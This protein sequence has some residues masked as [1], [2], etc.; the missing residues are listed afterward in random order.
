MKILNC[1]VQ[2]LKLTFLAAAF[3]AVLAAPARAQIAPD[4]EIFIQQP[5]GVYYILAANGTQSDGGFY[6][7]NYFTHEFDIILPTIQANGSFSGFS[8]I[9]NR[10]INGQKFKIWN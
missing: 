5:A 3:G 2:T 4:G 9:T 6:Y 10:S 8:A 7:L 1:A